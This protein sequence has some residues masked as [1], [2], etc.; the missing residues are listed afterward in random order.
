MKQREGRWWGEELAERD[1][2]ADR[3]QGMG[4]EGDRGGRLAGERGRRI[5]TRERMCR[6]DRDAR[7]PQEPVGGR[8]AGQRPQEK[9]TESLSGLRLMQ[10]ASSQRVSGKWFPLAGGQGGSF[11]G[12]RAGWEPTDPSPG[13]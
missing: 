3:L 7:T 11:H 9:G 6:A 4:R 5:W 10:L 12:G 13:H 8:R 1:P 2:G